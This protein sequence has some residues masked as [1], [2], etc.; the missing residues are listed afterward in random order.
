MPRK[1]ESTSAA[2]AVAPVQSKKK[3]T[4]V[5]A[6]SVPD[7]SSVS[8]TRTVPT[9]ESVEAEFQSLVADIRSHVEALNTSASG[10]NKGTKYFSSIIKRLNALHSHTMRVC[11][12]KTKTTRTNTNGGFKKP[13]NLSNELCAFMKCKPGEQRCRNDVTKFVC[14]YIKE[15]NLQNPED[16]R[17]INV[18]GDAQLAKLLAYNKQEHGVVKYYTLQ[19]LLKQHYLPE[20]ASQAVAAPAPVQASS[21][22]QSKRSKKAV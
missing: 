15:H 7:T 11:R 5:V 19:T 12:R 2:V 14:N 17:I 18:E 21:A 13:V 10:K 22:S 3:A 8:K 16:K 20:G 6:E 1:T 4:P 9:R